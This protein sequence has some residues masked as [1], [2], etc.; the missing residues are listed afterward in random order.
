MD[1]DKKKILIVDDE[2]KLL[3]MLKKALSVDKE[4]YDILLA[5]NAKK[6]IEILA[7]EEV[8]L[9]ISDIKMPGMSG[10][11]LFAIIRVTC[12]K[13]KVIFMTAYATDMIRQAIE[14]NSRLLLLEKPFSN[15]TL[16]EL[17]HEVLDDEKKTGF[18]GVLKDIELADIIQM[19]CLSSADITIRVGKGLR[20]GIVAIRDGDIIHAESSG[21]I[22]TDAF[23]DIISWEGGK[24][25]ILKEMDFK[26]RTI[27]KD[28][29]FL[30]IEGARISDETSEE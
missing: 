26:D 18:E 2:V 9:V 14:A 28:W 13:L 11:E 5:N 17:I 30:L 29:K 10:I 6:A 12:P 7:D 21:L 25:E 8:S 23:F 4:L 27:D 1:S 22:G 24:F 20:K 15:Q 3:D 19:C 16:R